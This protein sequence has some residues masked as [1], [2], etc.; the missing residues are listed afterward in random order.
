MQA[1][2]G[3]PFSTGNSV[4]VGI[5][6]GA[7][8]LHLITVFGGERVVPV[9]ADTAD[10]LADALRACGLNVRV[11]S[12]VIARSG[13][14]YVMGA[15][16][17]TSDAVLRA[18]PAN[19]VIVN[20]E[21]IAQPG[22]VRVL[23]QSLATAAHG[24]VWWDYSQRNL[25]ALASTPI[26]PSATHWVPIGAATGVTPVT[27]HAEQDIDVLFYGGLSDRRAHV[28]RECEALGLR[29]EVRSA[30]CFGQIR[31]ELFAHSKVILNLGSVDNSVFEQYRVSYAMS[32]GMCVVT[33]ATDRDGLPAGYFHGLTVAR[34]SD[35]ARTCRR[36]CDDAHER[37]STAARARPAV[38]AIAT[39]AFIRAATAARNQPTA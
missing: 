13:V 1:A 17:I 22:Q 4:R 18:L 6:P 5:I 15:H 3:A 39:A 31:D 36:L 32:R 34:Y 35:L 29:L 25:R 9:F 26:R 12:N 28:L 38:D 27:P 19:A 24:R 2:P 23:W 7:G 33:E 14:N 20:S 16:T 37:T 30:G 8:D 10:V 11:A 21:P